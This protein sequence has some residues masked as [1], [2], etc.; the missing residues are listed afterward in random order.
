MSTDRIDDTRGEAA[1]LRAALVAWYRDHRRDLPWRRTRDPYAIWISEVMLQQT[2]VAAVVPYWQRFLSR[3]PDVGAL[4]AAPLDEVLALWS[5]LGYYR[6]AR[7]LHAA[8]RALVAAGRNELPASLEALRA[9][10]GIGEYT[11]AAIGSI[12]FGIAEPV[13]DGNV[14]R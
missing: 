8:A 6:R 3:F 12:A 4:A 11:A 13:L 9:L 1:A 5:G 10:P 7:H 14:V 2:T